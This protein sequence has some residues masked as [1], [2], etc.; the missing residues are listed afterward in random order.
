M[1]SSTDKAGRVTTNEYDGGGLLTK[2][3]DAAGKVHQ[4]THTDSHKIERYV[5]P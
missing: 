2:T 1:L 3:V 4:Y 5:D